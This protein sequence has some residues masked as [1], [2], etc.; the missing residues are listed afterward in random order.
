MYKSK[1]F[2]ATCVAGIV[3]IIGAFVLHLEPVGLSSGIGII[4]APYLVAETYK[5]SNT[6]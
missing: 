3:F 5:P 2:I 6:K 1:R 4:L